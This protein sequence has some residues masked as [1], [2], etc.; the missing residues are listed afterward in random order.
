M[1]IHQ[2]V[3]ERQGGS[4]GHQTCQGVGGRKSHVFSKIITIKEFVGEV[5]KC[6][7]K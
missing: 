7:L 2:D 3:E 5:L 6:L 1:I 4:G